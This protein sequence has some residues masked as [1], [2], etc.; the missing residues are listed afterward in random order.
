M[1]SENTNNKGFMPSMANVGVKMNYVVLSRFVL[2]G[3]MNV[4]W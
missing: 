2:F 1:F 3:D 4:Y